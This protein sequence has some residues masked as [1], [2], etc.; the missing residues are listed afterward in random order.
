MPSQYKN[1]KNSRRIN[2]IALIK[3]VSRSVTFPASRSLFNLFIFHR[4]IEK[5]LF[6]GN[7]NDPRID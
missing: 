6:D 2:K 7:L 4:Y 1:I 3:K 5:S